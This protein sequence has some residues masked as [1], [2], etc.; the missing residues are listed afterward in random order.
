MRN[1]E[2]SAGGLQ[3]AENGLLLSELPIGSSGIIKSLAMN[4]L[5]RMRLL[6]LGFVPGT[7]VEAVRRS[8]FGDPV[9]FRV[10]GTLIALR[11]EESDKIILE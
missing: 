4:G 3:P 11:R 7:R 9:A 5:A 10:R 2:A 6:D 1:M 8:P